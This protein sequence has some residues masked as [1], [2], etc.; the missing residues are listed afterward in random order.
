MNLPGLATSHPKTCPSSPNFCSKV[1][2][3]LANLTSK[4]GF[5]DL[6]YLPKEVYRE[7]EWSNLLPHFGS[8]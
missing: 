4:G 7:P 6:A 2:S 3:S 5:I 1:R 8:G